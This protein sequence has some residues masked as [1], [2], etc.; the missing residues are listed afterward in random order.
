MPGQVSKRPPSPGP[1]S[2]HDAPAP[3]FSSSRL[4]AP[5]P[6]LLPPDS[7]WSRARWTQPIAAPSGGGCQ[8]PCPLPAPGC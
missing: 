3:A 4:P 8:P 7:F 6:R 5:F 1:G 2:P